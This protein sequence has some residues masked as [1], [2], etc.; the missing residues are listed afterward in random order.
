MLRDTY[1]TSLSTPLCPCLILTSAKGYLH[2]Y[3]QKIKFKFKPKIFNKDPFSVPL[4]LFPLLGGI[5][6]GP[7]FNLKT[8][9]RVSPYLLPKDKVQ[10]QDQVQ[11][12]DL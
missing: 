9:K 8:C 3:C 7:V 6:G 2:T 1:Q 5:Q 12:Q 4:C 10:A 11:T